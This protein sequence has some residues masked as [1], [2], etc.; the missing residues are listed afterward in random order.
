MSRREQ[1]VWPYCETVEV[2]E[3]RERRR[4]LLVEIAT[5]AFLLAC[6]LAAWQGALLIGGVL[7]PVA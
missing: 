4:R 1:V 3:R 2:L 5:A 7:A 6:P